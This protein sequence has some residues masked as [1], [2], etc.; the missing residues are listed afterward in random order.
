MEGE[1]E[2]RQ[3]GALFKD[4]DRAVQETLGMWREKQ[5]E[6]KDRACAPPQTIP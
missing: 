1:D 2:A 3:R 6:S 4:S 5:L